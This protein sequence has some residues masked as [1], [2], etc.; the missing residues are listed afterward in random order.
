M[1]WR[2]AEQVTSPVV[3]DFLWGYQALLQASACMNFIQSP[4]DS[5]QRP[6]IAWRM[7]GEDR[8]QRVKP[9]GRHREEMLRKFGAEENVDIFFPI[10]CPGGL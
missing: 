10:H 6:A 5:V 4:N 8:S 3:S 1:H 7:R 9:A 2:L